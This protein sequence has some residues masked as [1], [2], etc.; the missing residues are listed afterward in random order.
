MNHE[1]VT[2]VSASFT[3][4]TGWNLSINEKN[5]SGYIPNTQAFRKMDTRKRYQ[6]GYRGFTYRDWIRHNKWV[7]ALADSKEER[8]AIYTAIRE[9]D[10]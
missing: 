5:V 3:R 2:A 7:K 4:E 8:I 9:A 6:D 1:K 10:F